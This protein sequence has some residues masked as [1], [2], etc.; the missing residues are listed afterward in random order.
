MPREQLD[1]LISRLHE[2]YGEEQ[3]SAEQVRLMQELEQ[4]AHTVGTEDAKD[5]GPLELL[6]TMLDEFGEEHPQVSRVIREAIDAL[7]NM[8][9]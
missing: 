2:L 7:K 6:E 1:T 8:G 9:V 3:P 4:H 5:P